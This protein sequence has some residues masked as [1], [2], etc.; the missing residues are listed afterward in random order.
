MKILVIEDSNTLRY[1]MVK[2]LKEL[3]YSEITAVESAEEGIPLLKNETYDVL[4]LDWK[5]P[6]MSGVDLLRRIRANP[7]TASLS[8]IM[9]TTVHERKKILQAVQLGI[10]G[11]IIKPLDAKVVGKKLKEIEQ[12]LGDQVSGD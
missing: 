1:I 3:Q 5:L 7:S 11:Y 2:M 8:V 12:T 6:Q 9:V 10:Q 4:L